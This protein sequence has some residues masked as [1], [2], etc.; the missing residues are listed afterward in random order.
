M[1]TFAS[2]KQGYTNLWNVMKITRTAQVDKAARKIISL[3]DRY[4]AVEALVGTPWYMIGALHMRESS[5]DFRGVLHNG[6]NII[7]TG[8]KTRLVPKG[9]GPFSSWE[10]AAVDALKIKGHD[11]IDDWSIERVLYEC[12][13]FNGWGYLTKGNSPYVW[14]GSSLY[15]RG[16]YVRDHVYSSTAVDP[17]L[18]VAPVIKRILELDTSISLRK[19]STRVAIQ[20]TA[21]KVGRGL[22]GLGAGTLAFWDQV[23]AFI[24]DNTGLI[25]CVVIALL[26]VAWFIFEVIDN[27]SKKE[28]DDGRYIPSKEADSAGPTE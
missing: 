27:K 11:K 20:D 18:G 21:K 15:V 10:E 1:P 19:V 4:K 25:L 16:K 14:A 26:A 23:K 6:E 9:R 17:Q 24:S 13:R 12:E 28:Y 2:M 5:N 7:G 22:A 8:R 3:K